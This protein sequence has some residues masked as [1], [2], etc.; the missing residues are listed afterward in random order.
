MDWAACLEPE[1]SNVASP[2]VP[3]Q[4]S[5]RVPPPDPVECMRALLLFLILTLVWF[6]PRLHFF[7]V[8][9]LD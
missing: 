8:L 6:Q 7:E 3:P 4:V 1:T 5:P 9:F 2:R